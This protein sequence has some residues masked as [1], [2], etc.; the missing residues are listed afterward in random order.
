MTEEMNMPTTTNSSDMDMGGMSMEM[1]MTFGDW[2]DYQLKI[3]FDG[4]DVQTKFQFAL[5]W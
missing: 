3:V 5:S 4:W 1:V 2:R